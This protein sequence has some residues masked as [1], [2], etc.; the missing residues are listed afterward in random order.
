MYAFVIVFVA[1]A[2]KYIDIDI[3][4]DISRIKY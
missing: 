1:G 3:D 4:I 2:N